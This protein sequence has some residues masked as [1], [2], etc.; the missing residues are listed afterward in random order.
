MSKNISKPKVEKPIAIWDE[1]TANLYYAA[2]RELRNAWNEYAN[3]EATVEYNCMDP[4]R[5]PGTMHNWTP[6]FTF[7]KFKN[8]FDKGLAL[9]LRRPLNYYNPSVDYLTTRK[10]TDHLTPHEIDYLT[11]PGPVPP[12][13][14]IFKDVLDGFDK[15][16]TET[17]QYTADKEAAYQAERA[18]Q[19]AEAQRV[20]EVKAALTLI[21]V[22]ISE[23]RSDARK[24]RVKWSLFTT[25]SKMTVEDALQR[26]EQR[27]KMLKATF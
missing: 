12:P 21:E 11:T 4:D 23:I 13:Q 25:G 22:E 14:N 15:L 26:L 10:E 20:V 6:P 3:H 18:A 17:R 1:A 27:I 7:E 5:Q 19:R 9:R 2:S 8:A 16:T 24:A